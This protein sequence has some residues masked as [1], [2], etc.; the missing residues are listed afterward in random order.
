MRS[1]FLELPRLSIILRPEIFLSSSRF[2]KS[3]L[4]NRD[5]TRSFDQIT[6][7]QIC[8]FSFEFHS[9]EMFSFFTFFPIYIWKKVIFR[10]KRVL[11]E[12]QTNFE[13]TLIDQTTYPNR[14]LARLRL[15]SR[16]SRLS[17]LIKIV[18][19]NQDCQNLLRFVKIYQDISTLSRLFQGLQ[20]QKSWQFEKSWSR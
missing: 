3:R 17:R 15:S 5:G 6:F 11:K 18:E 10:L 8:F 7:F 9:F 4:L 20:V 13:R 14:D 12:R 2:L 16:L 1:R 19:T